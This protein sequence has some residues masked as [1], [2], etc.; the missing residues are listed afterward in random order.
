MHYQIEDIAAFNYQEDND[1]GIVATVVF[2]FEDHNR[3]IKVNV[4][5]DLD[6]EAPLSVIEQRLFDKAKAQLKELV[7]EI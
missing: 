4:R 2:M 3:N 6:R 5:I 7:S 1:S